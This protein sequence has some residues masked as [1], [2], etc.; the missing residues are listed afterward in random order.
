MSVTRTWTDLNRD[1]NPDCDLCQ[2]AVERRVWANLNLNFGQTIQMQHDTPEELMMGPAPV[3]LGYTAQLQRQLFSGMS[4]NAGYYR[5]EFANFTSNDNQFVEPKDFSH[6][7]I[8]APVDS[9]LPGGGGNQICGLYDV[10]P[11]LFGL[12]QTVVSSAEHYGEQTRSTMDS[13]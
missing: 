4:I 2:S 7:C 8:T 1:F 9:R 6:Y 11:A 10:S 13:T 5:R 3:Q 12:N